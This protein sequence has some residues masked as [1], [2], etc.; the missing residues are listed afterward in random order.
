MSNAPP[1]SAR[2]SRVARKSCAT[3]P[4]VAN[5]RHA[6]CE[7]VLCP[8][9]NRAERRRHCSPVA[10]SC[11]SQRRYSSW[12]VRSASRADRATRIDM[13]FIHEIWTE[14]PG[15]DYLLPPWLD[16]SLSIG[17]GIIDIPISFVFDTV[18]LPFQGIDYCVRKDQIRNTKDS[19]RQMQN[20]G[21][22]APLC[23]L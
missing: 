19:I 18:T 6:R 5:C 9:R 22:N 17:F 23:D 2:Q 12:S 14:W 3:S 4:M 7:G 15:S 8:R 13:M 11:L 16:S 10:R 1:R 20:I 21:T